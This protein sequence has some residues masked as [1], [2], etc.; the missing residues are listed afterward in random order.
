MKS[1]SASISTVLH[2]PG[3]TR[4]ASTFIPSTASSHTQPYQFLNLLQQERAYNDHTGTLCP[5]QIC[6]T[7]R[8]GKTPITTTSCPRSQGTSTLPVSVMSCVTT[9]AAPHCLLMSS[10]VNPISATSDLVVW[11]TPR[12]QKR[13]LLLLSNAQP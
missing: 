13:N 12:L 8:T 7:S 4:T 3:H 6:S 5:S 11:I 1:T 2:N 10:G 9:S